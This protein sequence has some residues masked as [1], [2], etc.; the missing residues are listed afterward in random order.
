MA[1]KMTDQKRSVAEIIAEMR[2]ELRDEKGPDSDLFV[3][4]MTRETR[5]SLRGKKKAKAGAKK[6]TVKKKIMKKKKGGK[7]K[8]GKKATRAKKGKKKPAKK[9][10]KAGKAKKK[11]K[12]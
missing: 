8:A 4:T 9:A 6:K 12:R 3:S 5:D 2:R 7:K 10:K 11:K 1:F